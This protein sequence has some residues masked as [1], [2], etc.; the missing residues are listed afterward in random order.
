MRARL[1]RRRSGCAAAGLCAALLLLPAAPAPA[2][3]PPAAGTARAAEESVARERLA[4]VREELRA[5][6][7]AR[8]ATEAERGRAQAELRALDERVA[9]A[10]GALREAEAAVA[11][12]EARARAL[13]GE[14][15]AIE[16]RLDAQ[17]AAIAALLRS[18]HALGRHQGLRLLL[19]DGQGTDTG[20]LLAYLRALEAD[21]R[22]R[23]RTLIGEL[24]ALAAARAALAAAQEALRG[25]RDARADRHEALTSVR[26]ARADEVAAIESRLAD[27]AAREAALAKDE[28]EVLA[29]IRRLSDAIADIPKRLEGGEAFASRRGRL[30]W[31]VEGRVLAAFGDAQPGG[32]AGSG[33]VIEAAAGSTVRAVSHGRVAYADWLRGYGMLV[34]LDH[35][36]GWMTLYGHNEALL[37]EV[38]MWVAA[39]DAIASAAGGERGAYFEVRARGRAQDPLAWLGR[40]R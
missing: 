10:A 15:A 6:R 24:E 12:A 13:A 40:R 37:A 28:A 5:A 39:G 25:Q 2:Q 38:G 29:L 7:S 4:R 17:R 22:T 30:P 20:R 31:P 33:I 35:G 19:G 18:V 14:A 34:I 36:D 9:A 16:A 27:A 32:R 8:E 1:R 23:V 21:R 26:R 11:A 3:A